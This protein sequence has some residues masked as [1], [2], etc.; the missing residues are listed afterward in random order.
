LTYVDRSV[1]SSPPKRTGAVTHRSPDRRAAGPSTSQYVH[2][3]RCV[4]AATAIGADGWP[5]ATADGLGVHGRPDGRQPGA[6]RL[7]DATA[8]RR[9]SVPA[10][11]LSGR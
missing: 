8:K 10:A 9:L 4:T 3:G 2:G 6:Y 5:A 11:K 7:S 1:E